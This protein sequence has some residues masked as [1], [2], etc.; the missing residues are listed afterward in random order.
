MVVA[1]N[2]TPTPPPPTAFPTVDVDRPEMEAA[3]DAPPRIDRRDPVIDAEK[4]G[5]PSAARP[6]LE[7]GPPVVVVV[8]VE[9]V[10]ELP[11]AP[12][13]PVPP[14]PAAKECVT[15]MGASPPDRVTSVDA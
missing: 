14:T 8:E 6:A 7:I 3:A 11:T 12:A 1:V 10:V 9:E 2:E 13:P 15:G 4:E 5:R